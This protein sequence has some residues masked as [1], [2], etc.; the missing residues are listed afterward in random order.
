MA[1][2]ANDKDFEELCLNIEGEI[3]EHYDKRDEQ[4]KDYD[5]EIVDKKIKAHLNK[6]NKQELKEYLYNGISTYLESGF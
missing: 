1:E 3:D 4:N 6:M 2:I 5:E